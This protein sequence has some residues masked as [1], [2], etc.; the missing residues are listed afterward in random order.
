MASMPPAPEESALKNL[1]A[2]FPNVDPESLE[3]VLNMV[4][5]D[6]DKAAQFIFDIMQQQEGV[7]ADV[8]DDGEESPGSRP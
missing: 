8:D 3:V 6:V 2:A 1:A 5:G 4:G 7:G